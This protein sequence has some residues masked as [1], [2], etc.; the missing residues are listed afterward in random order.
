MP[1][2]FK[3]TDRIAEMIKRKLAQ[4][5]QKEIKDPR[6]PAFLTVSDVQ[7]TKDLSHSKIFFTVLNGEAEV[8]TA[9]LNT[10]AAYLR[11]ALARTLTLRTVPQLHFIYDHSIEDGMRLSRLIDDANPPEIEDDSE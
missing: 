10:D 6:L 5:I 3:R 4:I 2:A 1:H 7:V 8:V 11:T 9:L